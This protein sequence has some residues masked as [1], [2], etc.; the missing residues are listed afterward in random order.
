MKSESPI[1]EKFF[2]G[3]QFCELIDSARKFQL[4]NAKNKINNLNNSENMLMQ[5]IFDDKNYM[6]I[7]NN[8]LKNVNKNAK[9]A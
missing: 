2:Y 6:E 3:T 8:N 9:K 1:S 4:E 7:K 5:E